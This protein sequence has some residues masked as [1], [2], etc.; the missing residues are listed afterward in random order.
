[1]RTDHVV[2]PLPGFDQHLGFGEALEDLTIEQFVKQRP[3]EALVVGRSPK[4]RR[5]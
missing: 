5:A 4:G 3:V 1:M 2:G